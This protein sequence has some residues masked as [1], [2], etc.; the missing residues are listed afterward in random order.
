MNLFIHLWIYGILSETGREPFTSEPDTPKYEN[1]VSVCVL[2][3]VVFLVLILVCSWYT[4]WFVP[5]THTDSITTQ[6][7]WS[8]SIH[9]HTLP[10]TTFF[11]LTSTQVPRFLQIYLKET[12]DFFG[13]D[14]PGVWGSLT[15]S[16]FISLSFI[17]P[18]PSHFL[19]LDL[20]FSVFKNKITTES[21]FF[22]KGLP[23]PSSSF[24]SYHL[25]SSLYVDPR[26]L[27]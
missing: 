24:P 14:H 26:F 18:T 21:S 15:S 17:T 8:V 1:G 5:G 19:S 3:L 12:Y 11:T 2:G 16:I 4:F 6:W 9:T 22:L 10:M 25:I 27:R 13:D 20:V 23:S 7:R